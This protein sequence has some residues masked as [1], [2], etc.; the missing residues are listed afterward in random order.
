MHKERLGFLIS[1]PGSIFDS[2]ELGFFH[3]Y[4]EMKGGHTPMSFIEVQQFSS[5]V[6]NTFITK[7]DIE[8][9]SVD[10]DGKIVSTGVTAHASVW[11]YM[12]LP[13]I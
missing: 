3:I 4:W 6:R 2:S 13:P 12:N 7:D 9:R 5:E 1:E 8:F 11:H 10:L